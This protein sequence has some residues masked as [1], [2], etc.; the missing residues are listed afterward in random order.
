MCYGASKGG[1]GGVLNA[2]VLR[3]FYGVG[4]GGPERTCAMVLLRG[5]NG[6]QGEQL[7]DKRCWEGH[8]LTKTPPLAKDCSCANRTPMAATIMP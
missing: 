1:G 5:V 4:G 3:C 8:Q 2:H 6:G 7:V